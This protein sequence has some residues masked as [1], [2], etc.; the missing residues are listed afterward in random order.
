MAATPERRGGRGRRHRGPAAVGALAVAR[1]GFRAV[2]GFSM[3]GGPAHPAPGG[4]QPV[5][6]PEFDS[7]IEAPAPAAATLEVATVYR[8]YAQRVARWAAR[9][10]G[11]ALD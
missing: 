9:L 1:P 8:V 6:R 10:G 2:P 3:K 11:P 5:H 4:W 7:A